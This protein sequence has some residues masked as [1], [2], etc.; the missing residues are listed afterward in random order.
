MEA[1]AAYGSSSED[2]DDPCNPTAPS[3]G[4]GAA[5]G[6]ANGRCSAAAAADA[7]AAGAP[8]SADGA[9]AAVVAGADADKGADADGAAPPKRQRTHAASGAGGEPAAAP[10]APLAAGPPLHALP[11]SEGPFVTL[12]YIKLPQHAAVLDLFRSLTASLPAGGS[13]PR[14]L[15]IAGAGPGGTAP[16]LSAATHEPLLPVPPHI[17]L[18]RP[19]SIPLAAA[20]PLL[21]SL[22]RRLRGARG[23][24]LALRGVRAFAN[25]E[26]TRTFAALRLE[27]GEE[28]VRRLVAA[29]DAAFAEHGLPTFYEEPRFHASFAWAPG[30]HAAALE[31]ALAAAPPPAPRAALDMAAAQVVCRVGKK[32][33]VVW[34]APL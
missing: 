12:A 23:G 17:S 19:V 6:A 13:L 1:L 27:G 33:A 16:R 2:E 32:E 26:R 30:D 8:A 24:A 5:G 34:S 25:E 22:T 28:T 3:G 31:A 20:R 4:S 11:P 29:V 10:A 9:A 15:P 7:A 21:A 14:F 18:S